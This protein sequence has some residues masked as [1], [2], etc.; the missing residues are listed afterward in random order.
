VVPQQE[1]NGSAGEARA[2][3]RRLY[4]R[5]L[6]AKASDE[7]CR[8]VH[9]SRQLEAAASFGLE[10]APARPTA[11]RSIPCVVEFG[12]ADTMATVGAEVAPATTADEAARAAALRA[13]RT[14]SYR[15]LSPV[16]N[17]IERLT[18]TVLGPGL[19]ETGTPEIPTAVTQVCWLNRTVRTWA[20]PEVL[21]DVSGDPSVTGLDIPRRLS[22]EADT[23]NH[24]A[25]SFPGFFEATGLT[26]DGLIVA[27][28]DSEVALRHPALDGRVVHRRNYTPES[29][30][31]PHS[32]GTA[33]AGIIAADDATNGGIAPAAT[34]YNYKVLASSRFLNGDD[35]GGT[36]AI[37]QALEDGA[38]VANCSWGAGPVGTTK[39]REAIACDTAWA[40]G[41]AV[42]KSAGNAGPGRATMTTPADADGVIVVGATNLAGTA[43]E[44]YSSRGPAGRISGPHLVAPGGGPDGNIA[45]CLVGGGF[46]DAGAGT[47]YAAPHVSGALT[48]LLQADPSR[49]PDA[50]RDHVVKTASRLRRGAG[51]AKGNG[52]LQ[53]VE[54]LR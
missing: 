40:L 16:Y 7:F 26:G 27:V 44:S 30:G 50:L 49:T 36:L 2:A 54:S 23:A 47:S 8:L 41:L 24:R 45:C 3:T 10:A 9:R 22:P 17:E 18:P 29:W 5:D 19:E 31:H 20:G 11:G 39:S 28:I 42:V 13:V 14:A 43:V 21:A 32:H 4:G 53:L 52:L 51:N 38:R 15:V 33:V 34:I 35:F 1:S 48:L 25:I 37:Q 6:E 12:P 46:G